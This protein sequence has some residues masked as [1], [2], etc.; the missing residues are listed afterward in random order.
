MN[1][2]LAVQVVNSKS[3]LADDDQCVSVGENTA[4]CLNEGH[5]IATGCEIEEEEQGV[6]RLKGLL[7]CDNIRLLTLVQ[8]MVSV[9]PTYMVHCAKDLDFVDQPLTLSFV[10]RDRQVHHLTGELLLGVNSLGEK[11]FAELATSKASV[12]QVVSIFKVLANVSEYITEVAKR[13]T[14]LSPLCIFFNPTILLPTF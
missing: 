10:V 3:N 11:D 14:R 6:V 8:F 5:E 2:A 12:R 1:H 13:R 4:M 7:Q 9:R